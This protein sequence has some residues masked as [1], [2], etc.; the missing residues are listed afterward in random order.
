MAEK[1]AIRAG[2]AA[3]IAI[4]AEIAG[5]A[6]AMLQ[7]HLES[8]L[9]IDEVDWRSLCERLHRSLEEN[10]FRADPPR[11]EGYLRALAV[12]L[13][14]TENGCQPASGWTPREALALTRGGFETP[15][16]PP[17]RTA[18]ARAA[19]EAVERDWRAAVSAA[20]AAAAEGQRRAAAERASAR[21]IQTEMAAARMKLGACMS[22]REYPGKLNEMLG[23]VLT[24]IRNAISGRA[25]PGCSIDEESRMEVEVALE[26]IRS[27][28]RSAVYS[29][30]PAPR[31]AA[32]GE[33]RALQ[34]KAS[35]S[36]ANF[37]SFLDNVDK[38]KRAI[39]K[40]GR[41]DRRAP[42]IRR[43]AS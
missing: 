32:E 21:A 34:I 40:G 37:Q 43:A 18:E 13:E 39:R 25:F 36:D 19:T 23:Y 29:V 28:V 38:K 4:R 26:E 11:R 31:T 17:A 1:K 14:M 41:D 10:I 27:A 30:D 15:Y 33:L 5:A 2:A 9:Q 7:E 12:L 8:E 24:G 3:L 6:E 16:P 22:A 20:M 42:A 35:R